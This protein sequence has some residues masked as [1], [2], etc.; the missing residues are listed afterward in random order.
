[1]LVP[2]NPPPTTFVERS[3]ATA[4]ATLEALRK[5]L[6]ASGYDARLLVARDERGVHLL[7]V[8]GDPPLTAADR[9]GARVWRFAEA[10]GAAEGGA[11]SETATA[12]PERGA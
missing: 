11:E 9:E 1:M 6:H 10:V 3:D 8:E 2:M 5:R 7:L 12:A 4:R